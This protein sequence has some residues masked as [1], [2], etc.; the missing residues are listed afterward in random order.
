MVVLIA[1][2]KIAFIYIAN[3]ILNMNLNI[4]NAFVHE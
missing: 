1:G 3:Y 2:Q 4:F